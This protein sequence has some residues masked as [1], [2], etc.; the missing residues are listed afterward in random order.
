MR[1]TYRVGG[2][3]VREGRKIARNTDSIYRGLRV[4]VDGEHRAGPVDADQM[5]ELPRHPERQV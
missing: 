1:G 4:G 3:G 2:E 5:V